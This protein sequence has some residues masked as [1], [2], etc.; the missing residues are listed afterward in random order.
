MFIILEKHLGE[1][2]W[3]VLVIP[4][5][6]SKYVDNNS[7]LSLIIMNKIS[8]KLLLYIPYAYLV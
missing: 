3:K 5:K 4:Y 8:A 1:V 2:I 7:E 6:N